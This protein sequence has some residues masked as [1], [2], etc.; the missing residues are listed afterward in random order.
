MFEEIFVAYHLQSIGVPHP[1]GGGLIN[2]TFCVDTNEG[3]FVLQ[4]IHSVIPD[5]A[6]QDMQ[7]VTTFLGQK[8]FIVPAIR[9]CDGNGALREWYCATDGTR[10]RVYPFL[11]GEVFLKV[12]DAD[13][14][15]SAGV[16]VGKMHV[17]LSDCPY[18]LQGSIP[19]F[20]DTAFILKELMIVQDQL[21][22]ELQGNVRVLV[23]ALPG[24]IDCLRREAKQLIHGDLKISNLLFNAAGSACGVIDFDTLLHHTPLVDMGDA[25]RSW[26]NRAREDDTR[27]F[28][29]ENIFQAALAGYEEGTKKHQDRFLHLTAARMIT[30]ELAARFLIDVVRDNYFGFDSA[31]YS[32]RREANIARAIG[33]IHLA[34]TMPIV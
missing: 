20:H 33:Q 29:D 5:A 7:R 4:K 30:F 8:G 27:A 28:F 1:M 9:L 15:H 32:T 3:K 19:H 21:P 23:N 22:Q 34:E 25:Y 2:A 12:R 31:Q 13:M 16:L 10:W 26:C 24:L 17:A 14:A 18:P 6:L 11:P